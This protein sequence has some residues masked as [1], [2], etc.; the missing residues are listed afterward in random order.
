MSEKPVQTIED[1]ARLA[2]V[3]KS[4]VSR[5]LNNSPLISQ[6]T[7]ERIQAIAQEHNFRISAPARNLSLRQS[8][9][10]AFITPDCEPDFFSTESLFG[11]EILGGIGNG[12]RSLGYDLLIVHVNPQD[13]AWV[14]SYFD[15]SRV[16]GFILMG[17]RTRPS[18]LKKLIEQKAPFIAWGVPLPN[19]RYCTVSGDNITGGTLA[20]HHLLQLG[21]QRIAF[22]G[23]PQNDLTVQHRFQG[24]ENALLAAG[25]SVDASRVIYGDYSHASSIAVMRRLLQQSPNLD[26]VFANSDLMAIGAI[27]VIKESGKRVPEDIAV[28]G[29]DDVSI[30]MYNNLPLTTIR[31]NVPLAGKLLAQNLIQYIQTAVVTN[32]TT[33]VE[34]VIRQSA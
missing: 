29:Y 27:Q 20:T 7:K 26:A 33:P 24:Y 17:S 34:L 4:T 13:N 25:H 6:Q 28:V 2:H 11:L 31:Q 21:R 18:L 30:A 32:V 16:D 14:N 22:L 9:T 19:F 15:S 1:I 10:I 3:S 5:A 8:H 23:G 12:L